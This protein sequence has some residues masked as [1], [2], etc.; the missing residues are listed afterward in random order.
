[1][2]AREAWSRWNAEVRDAESRR[3]HLREAYA[4]GRMDQLEESYPLLR[5]QPQQPPRAPSFLQIAQRA[6]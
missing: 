5:T 6:G 4:R 2:T 3:D 1:M